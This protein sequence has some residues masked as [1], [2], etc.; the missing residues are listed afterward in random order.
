MNIFTLTTSY[1][2]E[3]TLIAMLAASAYFILERYKLS[4]EYKSIST[5]AFLT[6]FLAVIEYY[7]MREFFSLSNLDNPN[8]N[9]PT[10]Y[11]Y[12]TWF[13]A[14]PIM[15]YTFFVISKIYKTNKIIVSIALSLNFLMIVSG[16]FS[17]SSF[18]NST[19]PLYFSYIMFI[20]GVGSWLG[21]LY[22]FNFILPKV[23]Q[24]N[25]VNGAIH[26]QNCLSIVN[27]FIVYGWAI[28]PLGL[29]ISFY[30]SSVET[31]LTREII[32]NFGD[33]FNKVGF[34]LTCFL[35]A[36]RLSRNT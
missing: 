31:A 17:E 28:Y 1:T 14:T 23:I 33:L 19:M 11:R 9:Y 24:R 4:N 29:V 13:I 25:N 10:E 18:S 6:T 12:I 7:N 35:C 2:F 32:Y 36:A 22:I 27:K 8:I 15:L 5:L 34:S 3:F 16:Y 26:I 20:I 21:I 30:D